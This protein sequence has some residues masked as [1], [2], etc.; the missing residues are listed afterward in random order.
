MSYRILARLAL[1]ILATS[2]VLSCDAQA[3]SSQSSLPPQ[4]NAQSSA[5]AGPATASG[6]AKKVWT[7][8]DVQGLRED[9]VISTFTEPNKRRAQ[10]TGKSLPSRGKDSKWYRDQISRLQ[11]QIP[12]LDSQI[13]ELQSAIDGKPTGDAK[14]ST[15]PY[16]VKLD[17]WSAEL[18]QLQSKRTGI[19]DKIGALEDEARHNGVAGNALP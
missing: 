6:G 17:S 2:P 5:Q 9:S 3:N 7:N 10:G 8:E 18:Q 16:G 1:L 12:P 11:S 15:R 19:L 14:N 13:A 4:T